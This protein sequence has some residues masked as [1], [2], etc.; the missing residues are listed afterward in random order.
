[1]SVGGVGVVERSLIVDR[2]ACVLSLRPV[3]VAP[4]SDLMA[5]V[6]CGNH[7]RFG[8]P[9]YRFLKTMVHDV[10]ASGALDFKRR[11]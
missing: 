11:N 8:R 1:M 3:S 5:E 6:A 10:I 7:P 4:G 9:R 2:C